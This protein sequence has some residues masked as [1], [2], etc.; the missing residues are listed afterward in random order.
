MTKKL[1]RPKVGDVIEF[2][3][4]SPYGAGYHF[5]IGTVVKEKANGMY[6]VEIKHV[7]DVYIGSIT[8]IKET[9]P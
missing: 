9:T 3:R 5:A 1:I 7:E 8:E 2:W 6:E 4:E